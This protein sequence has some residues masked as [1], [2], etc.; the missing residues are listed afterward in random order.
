M[1]LANLGCILTK[2]KAKANPPKRK[3][4]TASSSDTKNHPPERSYHPRRDFHGAWSGY[5]GRVTAR[6]RISPPNRL[7]RW[8]VVI[9]LGCAGLNSCGKVFRRRERIPN[10]HAEVADQSR[11]CAARRV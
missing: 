1:Q 6:Q 11:G 5:R 10:D 8:L 7:S 4:M 3:T 2:R 9:C